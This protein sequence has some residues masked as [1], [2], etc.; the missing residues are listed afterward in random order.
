MRLVSFSLLLGTTLLCAAGARA[1]MEPTS[2]GVGTGSMDGKELLK[3]VH[4]VMERARHGDV[5]TDADRLFYSH[6]R[7]FGRQWAGDYLFSRKFRIK[8]FQ[9]PTSG[10]TA[11]RRSMSMQFDVRLPTYLALLN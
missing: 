8:Y 5:P 9:I 10:S 3:C 11:V 4:S 6:R 1:A 7:Y 2:H